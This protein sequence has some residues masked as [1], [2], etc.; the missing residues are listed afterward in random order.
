MGK[1]EVHIVAVPKWVTIGLLVLVS[2]AMVSLLFYLSGKTYA[3]G[4]EPLRDLLLRAMQRGPI[5]PNAVLA[6][7][8]PA[9]ANVLFFVPWG[10]VMFL[11][12]DKPERSRGRTYLVTL[13]IG[14]LFAAAL[15]VWQTF[16]P[17]RVLAA[18]DAIADACGV[19]A[20]AVAGHLR[21]RIRIQF[22][23]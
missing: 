15:E 12:L 9:I 10:F 8:M 4:R 16:L 14:A 21:K 23:Y 13:V 18:P 6:S 5:S 11:V 20:G 17:T 2:A 3:D 7:V 1:R 19:L 22:D